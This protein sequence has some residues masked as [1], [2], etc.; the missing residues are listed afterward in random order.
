VSIDQPIGLDFT[1]D[2]R[3]LS[4]QQDRHVAGL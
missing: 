4:D 1:P 2:G 3:M